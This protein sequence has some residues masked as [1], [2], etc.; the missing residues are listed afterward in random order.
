MTEEV[1]I[2][3]FRLSEIEPPR[4]TERNRLRLPGEKNRD[5]SPDLSVV[6]SIGVNREEGEFTFYGL[7]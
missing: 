4:R 1:S 7:I 6:V 2:L 3:C 5:P